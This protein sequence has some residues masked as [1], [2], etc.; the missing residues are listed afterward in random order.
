M[1]VF[2]S[3]LI[4]A[5]TAL[6]ITL[7]GELAARLGNYASSVVVHGSG[8]IL[9]VVTLFVTRSKT[10]FR[11]GLS[12]ALLSGGAIGF[13]TVIFANLGFMTIGVSLTLALGLLGQT[14]SALV[15]DHRGWLGSPVSPLDARKVASLALIASGLAVM[16]RA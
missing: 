12:P 9:V 16:T 4:G 3:G 13:L 11:R 2:F 15:V 8:L 7:N 14:V 6:M 1:Y 5:L 10:P